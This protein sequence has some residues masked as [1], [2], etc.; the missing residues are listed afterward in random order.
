SAERVVDTRAPGLRPEARE[1]V[2]SE[3]A[4]NPLALVELPAVLD[5]GDVSAPTALLP[6]TARLEQAFA[7]R[8]SGL[9]AAAQTVLLVAALNDSDALSETL[10]AATMVDG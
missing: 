1:R 5:A 9:P 3:A 2:L 7:A 6:L 10:A 4:G 8:M